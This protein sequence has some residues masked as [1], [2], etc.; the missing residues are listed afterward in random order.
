MVIK[1][2]KKLCAPL[3]ICVALSRKRDRIL[4]LETPGKSALSIIKVEHVQR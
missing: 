4:A 2:S 3:A 1:S